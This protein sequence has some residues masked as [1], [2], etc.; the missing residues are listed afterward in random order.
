[1]KKRT[2]IFVTVIIALPGKLDAHRKTHITCEDVLNSACPRRL[3][4]LLISQAYRIFSQAF[5][6]FGA[7]ATAWTAGANLS[8]ISVNAS[9]NISN[10]LTL[11]FHNSFFHAKTPNHSSSYRLTLT[12]QTFHLLP[13]DCICKFSMF[14]L[15]L[16]FQDILPA[17]LARG[18]ETQQGTCRRRQ[19][20]E[21]SDA[22]EMISTDFSS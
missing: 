1:M 12:Y 4:S 18:H 10:I 11:T 20:D 16:C 9:S 21:S 14:F 15:P 6:D 13:T 8:L 5:G 22:L 17:P 19:S 2:C 3:S 7:L